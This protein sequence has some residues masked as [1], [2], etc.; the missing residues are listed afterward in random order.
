MG[1]NVTLEG[2]ISIADYDAARLGAGWYHDYN[3]QHYDLVV[4]TIIKSY[5]PSQSWP[6]LL[7]V[8]ALLL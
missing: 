6:S 7:C 8:S 3:V 2:G 5:G 4:Y 1:Y